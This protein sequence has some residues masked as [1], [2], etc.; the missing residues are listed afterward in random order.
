MPPDVDRKRKRSFD[1]P[2]FNNNFV[3]WL[4][5]SWLHANKKNHIA[6]DGAVTRKQMSNDPFETFVI[7]LNSFFSPFII[8]CVK[9]FHFIRNTGKGWFPGWIWWFEWKQNNERTR[10][11][12]FWMD[13]RGVYRHS[14]FQC[15]ENV[16]NE[17]KSSRRW[18]NGG[19]FRYSKLN[20]ALK[21]NHLH[22]N[23]A[24]IKTLKWFRHIHSTQWMK[25]NIDIV[26]FHLVAQMVPIL[27]VNVFSIIS[28]DKFVWHIRVL[29]VA[30]LHYLVSIWCN[31][32][33]A[34]Y[35]YLFFSTNLRKIVQTK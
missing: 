22:L 33:W 34:R 31:A 35:L 11:I 2:L 19:F 27:T 8:E 15:M 20:T 16:S 5:D 30:M 32:Y 21:L 25:I 29:N 6:K 13:T 28:N 26:I 24:R 12:F 18:K 3:T 23:G 14:V 9:M 10:T 1:G 4:T 17:S 7:S